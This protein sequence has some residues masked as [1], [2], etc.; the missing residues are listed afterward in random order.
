MQELR[1]T[2]FDSVIKGGSTKPILINA[3][4]EDNVEKAY[5]MKTYSSEYEKQNFSL[6]KEIFITHLAGEFDLP[7]PVCGVIKIDNNDLKKFYTEEEINKLDKGYK[8]CTEYHPGYV[9]MNSIVSQKHLNDYEIENLFAFDNLIMNTDRG[10]FRNKPNLLL[11]D[12]E[13]LLIDHEQTLAFINGFA[14]N[15]VNYHN[16]FIN[17]YYKNHIFWATLKRIKGQKKAHLFDEFTEVLRMLNIEK[18]KSVFDKLDFYGIGYGEKNII[19]AYLYW[20]KNNSDFI[21]KALLN[22]LNGK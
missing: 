1:L 7:V 6:A 11:K 10:G 20:A 21:N 3:I 9:I 14:Q 5:V 16:T 22:R 4:N 18:L 17:Y 19:F 15:E 12:N 13:M 8:F 2:G